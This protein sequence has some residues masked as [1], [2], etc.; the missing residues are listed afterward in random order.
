MVSEQPQPPAGQGSGTLSANF[1]HLA[2][3][4]ALQELA[5]LAGSRGRRVWLCGGT[6]RDLL[7]GRQPPDLDLAVDQGA[8]DLGRALAQSLRGA[9]VPLKPELDCCRVVA[10]EV[11]LDLTGLRR[12]SLDQDL[13]ARD[14]TI[15]ALAVDIQRL[16]DQTPVIIDPTG[17]MDDLAVGRLRAAGP[18]VLRQDPLR[19]LRAFRFMATHAMEP[20]AGLPQRLAGAGPGLFRVAAERIR[21]EWLKLMTG[22]RAGH[23]VMAM[24]QVQCLTRLVPS[25]AFGRGVSQNPYHH[26]DVLGHNLACL[27]ALDMIEADPQAHMGALGQEAAD[28]LADPGRRALLKTAALLHDLGK[29]ATRR[30]IDPGW[31][32]FYN[33]DILGA[34]LATEAARRLGLSRAEV[35]RIEL[36][37]GEHMRPFHLMGAWRRDK[38]SDRA[39]RRLVAAQDSHLPGVFVLAMADTMAGRGPQR[40]DDA[41]EVL[42]RLYQRVADLRDRELAA[43]LAAPP[44]IN[45]R[46]LMDALGLA[47]GREVGRLLGL[48]REAQLDGEVSNRDEALALARQIH[49]GG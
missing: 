43:R 25:L 3:H 29:P 36:L 31:A 46:E 4:P 1:S 22:P 5:C 23:A 2:R 7:L 6:L 42:L 47:P 14:F 40:P 15:N 34:R 26:L 38:L 39:I 19:V 41:E 11:E 37:V 24:D 35:R 45:G 48:V 33:H 49:G 21:V 27:A 30:P 10:G 18:G 44:L 12:P 8:M 9:F 32:T 16:G 13:A 20:A 17:G 28:Y